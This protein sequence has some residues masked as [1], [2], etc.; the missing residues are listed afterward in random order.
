LTGKTAPA[1]QLAASDQSDFHD[2]LTLSPFGAQQ[3]LQM[4]ADFLLSLD[5]LVHL[6]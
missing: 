5:G 3:E 4:E 2:V 6:G 1:L